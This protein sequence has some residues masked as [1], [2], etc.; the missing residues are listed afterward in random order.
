MGTPRARKASLCKEYGRHKILMKAVEMVP[1]PWFQKDTIYKRK[2]MC[3]SD[4]GNLL[5][6]EK[7]ELCEARKEGHK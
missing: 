6:R 2:A 7:R 3:I 4:E 1:P 5:S